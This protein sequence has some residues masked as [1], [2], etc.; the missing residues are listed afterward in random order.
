MSRVT[1]LG[2][3]GAEG[4]EAVR[5][6]G[7]RHGKPVLHQHCPLEAVIDVARVLLDESP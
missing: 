7:G 3:G 1:F 4:G 2:S 5:L 6:E